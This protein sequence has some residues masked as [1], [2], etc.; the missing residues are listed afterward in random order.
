MR[1][2]LLFAVKKSYSLVRFQLLPYTSRH[3]NLTLLSSR[4]TKGIPASRLTNHIMLSN[5]YFSAPKFLTHCKVKLGELTHN[6]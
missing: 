3:C 4:G 2:A 5:Q 1:G 6:T